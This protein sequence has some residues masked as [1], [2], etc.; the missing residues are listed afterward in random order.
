M[1]K[2][3]FPERI[4]VLMGI[5]NVT[6]DSF[7]DGAQFLDRELAIK[8]TEVMIAE[9]AEI[10]DIGAESTRPGSLPVPAEIQE[11]RIIPILSSLKEKYPE[12]TFSVDTQEATVAEKAIELGASIIND[13]SAL[14]T[15]PAL[16]EL[17]S[18]NPEVKVILMH[19]QGTPRTM[20]INPVYQDVLVEIKDFF[21]ERID[22]C[23]AKGIL[24]ENIMLDP[25]I[26]FGKN[27]EHNLTILGNLRTFKEFGLPLVV[28]ASRKSF[29]DKI[30]PSSP[31]QR[32]G[33]CLAAAFVSAYEEID[34]L[35]VHDVLLHRQFF[36]VLTAIAKAKRD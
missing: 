8:H 34:I 13:I 22:F 6:E 31:A 26:G 2:Y 15:D 21:Q 23:L 19:M 1:N 30:S 9:G 20:Q 25:G 11:Q 33:G 27:L 16:A 36:E 12:V 7:S 4:P 24:R 10:I 35:R 32:I 28:G 14:R 29:I 3:C 17:L 5:L 18:A